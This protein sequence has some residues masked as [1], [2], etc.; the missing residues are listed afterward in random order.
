[1]PRPR[2]ARSEVDFGTDIQAARWNFH[3]RGPKGDGAM[4][5]PFDFKTPKLVG[6]SLSLSGE[7]ALELVDEMMDEVDEVDEVMR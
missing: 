1:M 7:D 4:R 2:D 3:L 6:G 5:V